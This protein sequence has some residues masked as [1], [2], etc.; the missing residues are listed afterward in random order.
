MELAT[1]KEENFVGQPVDVEIKIQNN[2]DED[3]SV[4]VK[5]KSQLIQ[6]TGEV[7]R[8][9]QA[10]DDDMRKIKVA[11]QSGNIIKSV[12]FNPWNKKVIRTN[13]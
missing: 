6:Y 3:H 1:V 8:N 2:S 11:K 4:R 13:Q 7:A 12:Q 5:A 9:L 10:N